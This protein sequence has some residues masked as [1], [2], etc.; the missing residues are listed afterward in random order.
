MQRRANGL[1]HQR[2]PHR[3][4]ASTQGLGRRRPRREGRTQARSRTAG[5]IAGSGATP[6]SMGLDLAARV[7]LSLYLAH[8][9]AD[10]GPAHWLLRWRLPDNHDPA[11]KGHDTRQDA[12]EPP[13]ADGK[14]DRAETRREQQAS[15]KNAGVH[16]H[17][18]PAPPG[19][20][21]AP[22]GLGVFGIASILTTSCLP[23]RSA[24]TTRTT[25]PSA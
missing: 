17:G 9:P 12:F 20:Q 21:G 16:S 19:P 4:H 13:S 5:S 14:E 24:Y 25:V 22:G 7:V 3:R 8:E 10:L 11:D 6:P 18:S 2:S 23:P 15:L 1:C